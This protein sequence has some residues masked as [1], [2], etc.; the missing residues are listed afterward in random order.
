MP[1]PRKKTYRS[2][3]G[4]TI[5]EFGPTLWL[6]FFM[7]FFPLLTFGTVGLRYAFLLNAVRQAAGA[8]ALCSTFASDINPPL[9][10]AAETAA[11]NIAEQCTI[12]F[13]GIHLQRIN[14]YIVISPLAGG[15]TVRQPAPLKQP[16]N[17]SLNTYDFEVVLDATID[18]LFQNSHW[19]LKNIAGLTAPMSTSA[20]ADVFF[21]NTQGLTQ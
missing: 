19:P 8:G 15:T 13:P 20:R 10:I 6:I 2:G 7:F 12:A 11:T 16:A 17:P 9:D 18:P 21:E 5:V 1:H 4:T 3:R 14:C